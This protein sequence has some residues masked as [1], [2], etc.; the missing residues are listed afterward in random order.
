MI[1]TFNNKV[2]APIG[3]PNRWYKINA[4]P[5]IPATGNPA[6]DAKLYTANAISKPPTMSINNSFDNF[7]ISN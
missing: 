5:E 7:F 4:I 3:S 1:G 6:L 2:T